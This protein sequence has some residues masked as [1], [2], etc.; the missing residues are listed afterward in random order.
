MKRVLTVLLLVALLLPL[1]ACGKGDG[2]ASTASDSTA[3]VSTVP[4]STVPETEGATIPAS[5]ALAT[6]PATE[7][8]TDPA[9]DPA[10]EPATEPASTASEP[11]EDPVLKCTVTPVG[12]DES[13]STL[14]P[15]QVAYFDDKAENANDYAIGQDELSL[16]VPITLRWDVAFESGETLLRYFVVRIWTKS[17]RS[18]AREFIVGRSEREYLFYNSFIGQRYYWDVTAYGTD[19]VVV[20]SA[21]G[22][23]L[24]ENRSFRILYVDGVTNVRDLGGKRTE[25]GG[26]VR[27]GMMIRGGKFNNNGSTD[28]LITEEGIR[29]M[30]QT[31]GIKTELDLRKDSEATV[32]QSFLGEDVNYY[33]RP[34]LGG[35]DITTSNMHSS[36]KKIFAVLADENNYPIYFHCAAGTDRTGVVAWLVNGLCGVSEEDLWRDFMLSNFGNIGNKRGTSSEKKGYV[37]PLKTAPGD[38]FA[39]QIYN[40]LKDEV[41]IPTSDLDAVIRIM[42]TTPS[43]ARNSMPRIP[44][45]H[46]HEPE[47]DFT[48]IETATCTC[49]GI[50]VKYCAVCGDFIGETLSELPIDPDGH[51]AD[52]NVTRQ[53]TLLD[54]ADGSRNGVCVECGRYVEQTVS[55]APLV[56]KFTDESAGEYVSEKINIVESMKGGHFYPTADNPAGNDL[57]I[58][59]SIFYHRTALNFQS[60]RGTYANTRL[61]QESVIYWSPSSDIPD[62]WCPY[63]GGFEGTGNNFKNPVSD[64]EVTT[65]EKIMETGG[66]YADYPNIGGANQNRA[67]Y[68]WHRIGI[69]IHEELTNAA[70]LKKDATAGKTK[71]TYTLTITVYF[72]GAAAYKL[73]T[74]DSAT[75]LHAQGNLL[76]TAASDGKGGIV[77]TD[78]GADRYVIPLRL[79]ATTAQSG[80]TVYVATADVIVSCGKD[81]VMQ[82]EKT[83]S[84]TGSILTIDGKTLAASIYYRL[85]AD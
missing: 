19:G 62:S 57:L 69:R 73:R 44:A 7:P 63:A 39:E 65:S 55:F 71:A 59:Y 68:G 34:L 2:E 82:V 76:F 8:A 32:T 33:V 35:I 16:P 64:G 18:D 58:E 78:I 43:G 6:D 1:C 61:N 85:K 72:D 24:T 53:P 36:L 51:R 81:F 10:T 47:S 4:A 15:L 27:Q 52:W 83:D 80:K 45:G 29:T 67:E 70:A 28:P 46:V 50:Q 21:Q 48:V 25:D 3:S 54:Q 84:P 75:P 30:R 74:D 49:P 14:T 23:F 56:A 42:K 41:G 26:R 66:T 5:T 60:D 22:T 79:N 37:D 20:R 77:Y 38:T 17:D 13:V 12:F 40:Y 9:T 11:E 31:F